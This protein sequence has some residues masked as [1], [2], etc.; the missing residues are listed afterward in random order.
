MRRTNP[1]KYASRENKAERDNANSILLGIPAFPSSRVEAQQ[2]ALAP[3]VNSELSTR[4][5][6]LS[7]IESP[8]F[9]CSSKIVK[10]PSNFKEQE[11]RQEAFKKKK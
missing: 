10:A 2:M 1:Q 9:R 7:S 6:Q 11:V 5:N 8:S 3:V 4:L